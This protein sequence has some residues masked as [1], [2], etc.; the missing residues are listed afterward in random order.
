VKPEQFVDTQ[1]IKELDERGYIDGL[2]KG[3]SK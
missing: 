3:R 1:F 2:Y